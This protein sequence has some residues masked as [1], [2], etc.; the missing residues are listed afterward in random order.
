MGQRKCPL[1]RVCPCLLLAF[2]PP[3]VVGRVHLGKDVLEQLNDVAVGP[4]SVPF[5]KVGIVRCGPTNSKGDF[6]NVE[7]GGPVTTADAI[8]RLKQQSA[9]ARSAVL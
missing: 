9:S 2:P 7:A 1:L 8:A 5:L 4:D 6:E 3:Q